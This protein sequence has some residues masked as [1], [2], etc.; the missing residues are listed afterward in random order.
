MNPQPPGQQPRHP[1]PH[2][3]PKA[4]YNKLV[5]ASTVRYVQRQTWMHQRS[6]SFGGSADM[7]HPLPDMSHPITRPGQAR[8]SANSPVVARHSPR[9]SSHSI[10]QQQALGPSW[11]CPCGAWGCQL[12]LA[13]CRLIAALGANF[14]SRGVWPKYPWRWVRP[15]PGACR[16]ASRAVACGDPLA[17]EASE[18]S[19]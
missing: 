18:G 7:V 16:R 6:S 4:R 10:T 12:L 9:T 17:H 19:P 15:G 2:P 5:N 11:K 3:P 13:T 8:A 14:V 1:H